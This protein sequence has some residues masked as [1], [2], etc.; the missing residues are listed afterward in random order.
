MNYQLTEAQR[1][2]CMDAEPVSELLLKHLPEGT[3]HISIGGCYNDS[4][5]SHELRAYAFKYLDNELRCYG[6]DNE[7][8]Y[9]AWSLAKLVFKEVP[10][11]TPLFAH[12]APLRELSD[13]Q[14]NAIWSEPLDRST[15][16]PFGLSR[17]RDILKA[18]GSE[19]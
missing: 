15:L 6:T 12:P 7:G 3:T 18:A 1:A 13:A 8:E 11:I 17:I 10:A 16:S 2:Q 14:I 19:T 4:G 9:G 5:A